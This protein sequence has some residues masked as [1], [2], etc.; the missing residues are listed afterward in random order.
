MS[1]AGIRNLQSLFKHVYR[2]ARGPPTWRLNYQRPRVYCQCIP[3]YLPVC[4]VSVLVSVLLR[5]LGREGVSIFHDRYLF[6]R[7][8]FPSL[9]FHISILFTSFSFSF[10]FIYSPLKSL[11]HRVYNTADL[12]HIFLLFFSFH[13]SFLNSFSLSLHFLFPV[14]F[15][16]SNF[17]SNLNSLHVL[18]PS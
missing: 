4:D 17:F 1:L 13:L 11:P 15:S 12:F 8:S 2:C 16:S 5:A 18:F 6:K 10:S 9:I 3:V 14:I 7:Q